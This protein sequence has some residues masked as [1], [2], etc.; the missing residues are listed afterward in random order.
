M[1]AKIEVIDGAP[2]PDLT[3]EPFF[4]SAEEAKL[5]RLL[6]SSV[7]V[8]TSAIFF[9]RH[10]CLRCHERCHPHAAHA[11]CSKCNRWVVY[12]MKKIEREL[13]KGEV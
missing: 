2:R 6:Q 10:G 9:E 12:E 7:S 1:K 5:I 13:Q 8:R 11:L 4:R 3:L